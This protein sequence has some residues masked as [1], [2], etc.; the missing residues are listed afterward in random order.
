MPPK[1]LP[2]KDTPSRDTWQIT[3]E[4]GIYDPA[5]AGMQALYARLGRPILSASPASTRRERRR[6]QRPERSREGVG[7]AIEEARRR[8]ELVTSAGAISQSPARAMRAALKTSPEEAA[9]SPPAAEVV[10]AA[11]A[12]PEVLPPAPSRRRGTKKAVAAAVAEDAAAAPGP[13]VQARPKGRPAARG[14]RAKTAEPVAEARP[15]APV[16]PKRSAVPPAPSPRRPRG[17]V[18]LAAWA[19]V[20]TDAPVPAPRPIDP[21]GFWRGVFRIPAEVALVEYAHGCRIQRLLI[22]A[23]PDPVPDFI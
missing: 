11:A 21:R 15:I 9:V 22:E 1:R 18:P 8:A 23:A 10:V 3:D 17:P 16:A 4:W 2:P 5:K 13:D 20:V 14:R 19:R 12:P 7:L 6:G